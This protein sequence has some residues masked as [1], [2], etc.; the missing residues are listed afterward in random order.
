MHGGN[1]RHLKHSARKLPM[2]GHVAF[3]RVIKRMNVFAQRGGSWVGVWQHRADWIVGHSGITLPLTLLHST[4]A[5]FLEEKCTLQRG[6]VRIMRVVHW[7]LPKRHSRSPPWGP[8]RLDSTS[9]RHQW[10]CRGWW[11]A[12]WCTPGTFSRSLAKPSG[13][14]AWPKLTTGFLRIDNRFLVYRAR[15]STWPPVPVQFVA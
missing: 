1:Q 12:R 8:G 10:S 14:D 2:E 11:R 15:S 4:G 13:R 3:S 9:Q 7:S 6:D 5:C